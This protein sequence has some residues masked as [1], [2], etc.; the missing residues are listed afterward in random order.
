LEDADNPSREIVLEAA[1]L[2]DH[3]ETLDRLLAA[4]GLIFDTER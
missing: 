3:L 1:R 4:E 2:A